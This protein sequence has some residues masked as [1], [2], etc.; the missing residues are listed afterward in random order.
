MRIYAC[1]VFIEYID[2]DFGFVA[3]DS[4]YLLANLVVNKD[5]FIISVS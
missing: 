3:L 4:E 2:F 1:L 5:F